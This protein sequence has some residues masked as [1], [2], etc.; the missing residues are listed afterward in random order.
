MLRAYLNELGTSPGRTLDVHA[1]TAEAAAVWVEEYS[2]SDPHPDGP[3]VQRLRCAWGD[4]TLAATEAPARV[5]SHAVGE[6]VLPVGDEATLSC[7]FF[8]TD[9]TEEVVIAS[10]QGDQGPWSLRLSAEG[11][12]LHD[13]E[14]VC[15]LRQRV[16]ERVWYFLGVGWG[17]ARE[18]RPE[19]TTLFL[20]HWGRTGGPFTCEHAGSRPGASTPGLRIGCDSDEVGRMDGKLCGLRVHGTAL[21]IVELTA[22]MNGAGPA[23]VSEWNF[24]DRTD[25]DLVT[26]RAASGRPLRLVHAPLRSTLVP[27]RLE[28]TGH[29]PAGSGSIHFHRDDTEDCGWPVGYRLEVPGEAPAG[30][31]A[32]RLESPTESLE[33]PFVVRGASEITL[34]VPTLTWQAYANLGRDETWPGLS[35]YALHSDGSPVAVTTALRPSQ[36]FAPSARLE[37]EAGDGFATGVN[38]AH[39]MLADLYAWWWLR[40]EF[41]GRVGVTD[42][43]DLHLRGEASLRGV[44]VLVLSAHPEYWTAAMLDAIQAHLARGGSVVYLGGNGLYWVTSLHP[45]KPHLMEIRRWGGS[46]TWSI[47]EDDR[48]HQFEDRLGGLWAEAGRPPNATVGV[49]FVGFGNG[50]SLRFT[51]TPESYEPRW[52]WLFDGVDTDTI[53]AA[54]VNTGAGNEFDAFDPELRPPGDSVV[55]ARSAPVEPDHF[56]AYE[57]GGARAPAEGLSSDIVLTRTPAGGYVL[58]FSSITASG[59]LVSTRDT[60]F[61][62]VARNGVERM[63]EDR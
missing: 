21:D 15:R 62:R 46:Q 4:G 17:P 5:G 22:V 52:S 37:V 20:A 39:L 8:P 6:S 30:L 34:L 25:P 55:V 3:G 56:A 53:G 41:P 38:A 49:G 19:G 60:S 40:R 59:C 45:T 33:L 44:R 57:A 36:T 9:L 35:H 27:G 32:L 10:W 26:P 47:E 63:L 28:S 50:P 11:L 42:D 54:G 31:Y 61:A 2:H 29:L 18:L 1:S 16:R 7:W 24:A 48:L 43:R 13:G 12:A 58:A 14:E 23:P 51:R